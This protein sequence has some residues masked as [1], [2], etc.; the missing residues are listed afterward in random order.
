MKSLSHKLYMLYK[1]KPY[2]SNKT[3]L[4]V[5]KTYI[6]P[7]IE[8]GDV[9]IHNTNSN[10]LA[11]IQRFQNRCIKFCMGLNVRTS[12]TLIHKLARINMLNERRESHLLNLAYKRSK[13]KFFTEEIN[14]LTRAGNAP[15]L[16][17]EIP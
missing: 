13:S 7:V 5:Y 14:I 17:N 15:K 12:T 11:K 16:K 8:Y 6:L 9:I 2:A 4:L 1:A 3:L 10:L